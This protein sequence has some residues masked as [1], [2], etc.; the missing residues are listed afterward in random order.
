M[1]FLLITP[2]VGGIACF[3]LAHWIFLQ[4]PHHPLNRLAGATFLLSSFFF[5]FE[6]GQRAGPTP[7]IASLFLD[8]QAIAFPAL[9]LY[10]HFVWSWTR[11][12][13]TRLHKPFLIALYGSALALMV[14]HPYLGFFGRV[15]WRSELGMWGIDTRHLRLIQYLGL[16]WIIGAGLVW[17]WLGASFYFV[18]LDDRRQRKNH[19]LVFFATQIPLLLTILFDAVPAALGLGTPSM[20]SVYFAIGAGFLVIG[21]QRQRLFTMSP[22]AASREIIASMSEALV[23]AAADGVIHVVNQSLCTLTGRTERELIGTRIESLFADWPVELIIDEAL[24]M[25]H[26]REGQLRSA[27]GTTI[28]VLFSVSP[29]REKTG[30]VYGVVCTLLDITEQKRVEEELR[31]ARDSAE[32]ASRAKSAFL[33]TMSHEIRTPMN[34]VIGMADLLETTPLTPEQ[35]MYVRTIR[36]SGDALLAIINDV[37]DFSKIEAGRIDLEPRPV[38]L[39]DLVGE[40][41]ELFAARARE[42]GLRLLSS[43]ETGVPGAV[44]SIRRGS[45]RCSP[46]CSPTRSSSPLPAR[47]ELTLLSRPVPGDRT[48]LYWSVRDTGIGIPEDNLGRLFRAFSQ[49]DSSITRK[50]GGTGLGLAISQRLVE[51]MGGKIRVET[52]EGRG[53]V[54]RFTL[55]PPLATPPPLESPRPHLSFDGSNG[56][57]LVVEDDPGNRRVARLMLHKLGFEVDLVRNG[58]EAVEAIEDRPY[59]LV[60][61]DVQMPEMDGLEATREIPHPKPGRRHLHH[62]RHRQRLQQRA[63]DSAWTQA[64]TPTS[65]NRS[66]PRSSSGR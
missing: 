55:T 12:D 35:A 16:A 11:R 5:F 59:E 64:W 19:R 6:I 60:L 26:G 52:R 17:T 10:L 49:G 3:S 40:A 48:V 34:G 14:L 29:I 7:Q 43:V 53:S 39:R 13:R 44:E 47:F 30:A 4:D 20:T 66:A 62:R 28:P 23:L 65:P 46:T 9:A 27:H 36:S 32:A 25:Q 61:M 58:R 56:R 1:W 8:L 24:E 51:L 38:V 18:R 33:A 50:F 45:S 15:V 2:L 57:V 37:L 63:C 22:A 41:I 31:N 54:F 21:M 42:K